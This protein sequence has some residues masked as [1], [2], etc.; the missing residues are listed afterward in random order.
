LYPKG[1]AGTDRLA[2]WAVLLPKGGVDDFF[3]NYKKN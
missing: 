3:G 2:V 1:N